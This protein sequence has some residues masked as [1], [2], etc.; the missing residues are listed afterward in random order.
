MVLLTNTHTLKFNTLCYTSYSIFPLLSVII[1]MKINEPS[2]KKKQQNG[3]K[4][5]N[6]SPQM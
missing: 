2:T 1:M 6:H 4:Y 3:L 5:S